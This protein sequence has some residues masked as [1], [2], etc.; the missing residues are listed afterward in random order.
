LPARF[1][2]CPVFLLALD[3]RAFEEEEENE[4]EED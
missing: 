1:Q 4:E 3:S 2:R